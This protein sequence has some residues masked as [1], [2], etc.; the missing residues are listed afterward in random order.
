MKEVELLFKID[1]K[2]AKEIKND[3]KYLFIKKASIKFYG[4][5]SNRQNAPYLD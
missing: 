4:R 2:I 1:D 3:L 5:L